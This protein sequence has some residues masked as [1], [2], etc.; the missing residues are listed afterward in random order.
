AG[1]IGSKAGPLEAALEVSLLSRVTEAGQPEVETLRTEQ[2]EEAVDV[3]R[4]PHR[5]DGDALLVE[6]ATTAPGQCLEGELIADPLNQDDRT[7][8][9][10][11]GRG[12][13]VSRPD[14]VRPH[15]Q[16]PRIGGRAARLLVSQLNPGPTA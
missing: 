15:A 4:A 8:G 13:R 9:E 11:A 3:L 12:S 14:P 1:A 7:R 6:I 16:L 10:G 2:M 5:H